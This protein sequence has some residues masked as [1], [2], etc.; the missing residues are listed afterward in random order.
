M[1]NIH[2]IK[3]KNDEC[4]FDTII[5]K[6]NKIYKTESNNVNS[7]SSTSEL[8][9]IIYQMDIHRL[10]VP[11][12]FN[13]TDITKKYIIIMSCN[14]KQNIYYLTMENIVLQ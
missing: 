7:Y 9:V 11:C 2:S 1:C 10:F 3:R 6:L 8:T 4:S 5:Q 12:F 14:N 13:N